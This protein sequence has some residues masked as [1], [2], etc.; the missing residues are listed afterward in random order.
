LPGSITP[1]GLTVYFSSDR[2]GSHALF[3]ATRETVDSPF[4]PPEH[5]SFFDVPGGFCMHPDLACDGLALYFMAQQGSDPSTRD[6]WVS[7]ATLPVP[8][9]PELRL[10]PPAAR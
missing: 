3:R 6:I 10:P 5:L 1:D 8:V 2:D 7:Y 4:G 9:E